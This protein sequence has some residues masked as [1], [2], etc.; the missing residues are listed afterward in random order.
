M[1]HAESGSKMSNQWAGDGG[2]AK[3]GDEGYAQ[4][5]DAG[6]QTGTPESEWSP[7]QAGSYEQDW[8]TTETQPA[9][10]SNLDSARLWEYT[11][12][13][14]LIGVMIVVGFCILAFVAGCI[15]GIVDA[16]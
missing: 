3:K 6:Y 5:A 11:K 4:F 8:G 16:L 14:L 10:Q 7:G 1:V 13:L 15:V 12:R 2:F 9:R